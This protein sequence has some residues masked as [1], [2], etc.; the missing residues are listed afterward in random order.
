VVTLLA[1][2]LLAALLFAD[3]PVADAFLATVSFLACVD[4]AGVPAPVAAAALAVERLV[5]PF[6]VRSV[7]A[8]LLV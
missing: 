8:E 2:A 4:F 6:A 5:L 3:A 7:E 1:A